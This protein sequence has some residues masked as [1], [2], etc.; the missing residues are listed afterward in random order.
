MDSATLRGPV[1]RMRQEVCAL[2][3]QT[4]RLA[5]A[6]LPR[7]NAYRSISLTVCHVYRPVN[8]RAVNVSMASADQR[9]TARRVPLIQIADPGCVTESRSVAY[10]APTDLVLLTKIVSL[11]NSV[12]AAYVKLSTSRRV[13]PAHRMLNVPPMSARPT[14]ALRFRT[15]MCALPQMSALV[16]F[17]KL[18]SVENPMLVPARL[19]SIAFQASVSMP[20]VARQQILKHV[21]TS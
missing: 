14:S 2:L 13:R 17:V 20:N 21:L 19:P 3:T 9:V 7:T 8:V 16:A 12:S 1:A 10:Q 6:T 4:A 15:G 11:D 18:E 5:F